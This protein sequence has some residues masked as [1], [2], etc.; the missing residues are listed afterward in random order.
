MKSVLIAGFDGLQPA[1][2]TREL[3]PNLA[4]FAT[5]GVTFANHHSAF[6]TVTRL[7]AAS[8]VTGRYPGGHGL[9]ANNVVMRDFDPYRVFSALE[10]ALAEVARKLPGQVL[11]APTLGDILCHYGQEYVS[12]GVGT[13]GNAYVQN[14]NAEL[15]GGATIHPE[16]CLPYSL[17]YEIT[18][19]FGP[20][21]EEGIPNTARYSR[22]VDIMTKYVIGERRPVVALIWSSEP[23]KAQHEH[24]VGSEVANTAIREADQQFGRLLSW[25]RDTGVADETDVL[26]VS[27][28]GYSTIID[29]V[30]IEPLVRDAG[31]PP[32]SERDGVLVVPNGG[33]VLFYTHG[34]D[35]LTADLMAAWLMT[36]PWCGAII[37]SEAMGGIAGTLPAGLVGCEGPRVPD[38][39]I[40]FRWNSK[41][42]EAGYAGHAY[43]S[44][45]APGLG[46]HGTMS[47]SEIQN[48]LLGRGPSFKRGVV[49]ES[50][51]G[52]VDIVPTI[53]RILDLPPVESVDG[54]VLEEALNEGPSHDSVKWSTGVHTAERVL[55]GGVYRQ[56]ISFSRVYSTTYIDEG[57]ATVDLPR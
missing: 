14:P 18:S 9:A 24:G 36:R 45:G 21:P 7:N 12:V 2:V 29:T 33:S 52:N 44:G 20:W 5:E 53:F 38:L 46:Q 37:T 35:R 16:F 49:V 48:V 54:R 50:P 28:H 30:N 34:K 1:Q 51:S 43:S 4:A 31:F 57:H 55:E 23:D 32:G 42:N 13:T 6:P 41:P 39:A 25:L 8:I 15:V 47:R 10:P 22:A 11:L 40:S 27:D 56:Q 17:H 3:M 19:R 26:V